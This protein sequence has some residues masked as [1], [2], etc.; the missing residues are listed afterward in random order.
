[1]ERAQRDAALVVLDSFR[2]GRPI[3]EMRAE[4]PGELE[5]TGQHEVAAIVRRLFN[6]TEVPA[7]GDR[8]RSFPNLR[9][10]R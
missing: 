10:A 5:A 1:M 8:L 2:E 9:F 4:L 7:H 6:K 3:H